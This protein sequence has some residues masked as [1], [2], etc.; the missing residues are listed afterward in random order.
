MNRVGGVDSD[1]S[2]RGFRDG[3]GVHMTKLFGQEEK[4]RRRASQ[5][6]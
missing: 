1:R 3:E 2:G 4:R 5:I 6:I